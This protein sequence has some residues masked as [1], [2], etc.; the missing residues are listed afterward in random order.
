MALTETGPA[1]A[2]GTFL[3]TGWLLEHCKSKDAAC[4]A[5]IAGVSDIMIAMMATKSLGKIFCLPPHTTV[6]QE[7]EIFQDEAES[8]SSSLDVEAAITVLA[9][10]HKT[11]KCN[12]SE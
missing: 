12:N 4:A 9:A 3:K 11:Y 6:N 2:S 10:L 8:D 7:V 1:T 5:Y